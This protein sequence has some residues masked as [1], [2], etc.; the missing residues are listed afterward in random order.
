MVKFMQSDFIKAFRERL[1][2]AGYYDVSIYST[3][4]VD[5]YIVYVSKNGKDYRYRMNKQQIISCPSLVWFA[6]VIFEGS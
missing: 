2:R 4:T 3:R 5:E 6:D 1:R